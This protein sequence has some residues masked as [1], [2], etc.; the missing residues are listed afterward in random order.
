MSFQ[1]T[2]AP[3]L[4]AKDGAAAIDFY[5]KAFGAVEESLVMQPD[6]RLGHVELLIDGARFM[7]A[8]EFPEY[9]CLSP[10]TLGGSPVTIHLYVEDVDKFTGKA[11]AAGLKVVR[12]VADQFYGDRGGKF[13]DPFGHTWWIATRKENL[14][15]EEIQRRASESYKEKKS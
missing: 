8:G 1:S 4:Y 3:Y 10:Q 6:G 2:I 12:P 7:L 15:T 9:G 5:K 14:S 13:Q 11:V